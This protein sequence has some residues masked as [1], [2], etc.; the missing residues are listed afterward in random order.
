MAAT[1][2]KKK[3][4]GK[5]EEESKETANQTNKQKKKR[6]EVKK[7]S[8]TRKL[9]LAGCWD[10]KLCYTSQQNHKKRQTILL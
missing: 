5:G 4:K 6:K 10:S 8:M 7:G 2:A 3:K 1:T 9:F